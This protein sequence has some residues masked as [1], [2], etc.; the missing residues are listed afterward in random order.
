MKIVVLVSG[1]GS[2]LQTVLD[3]AD[4]GT[5]DV[6]VLAVVSNRGKAYALERAEQAEISTAYVPFKPYRDAG[7]P[8]E[9]YD[10]DLANLVRGFD[11]DWVVCLGWMHLFSSA[12]L[13]AFPGRVVNLH[14]AL[15]GQFPG[16]DAIGDAL[17]AS[18][19]TG[20]ATTG[21][22]MHLV[23][24]E[25]DA[26]PVLSTAT[27]PIRP[28]DTRDTLAA[29]MHAAEHTL[30]IDVLRALSEDARLPTA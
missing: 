2:N 12:F 25:M 22:M 19:A 20:L 16:K 29:R 18:K 17:A 21:C 9:A 27:V 30:V 23:V 4:A 8:R 14:P 11:P 15:P 24:P 28:D 13:D 5:L 3:A 6:E 7:Q 10:A 26:G 1:E